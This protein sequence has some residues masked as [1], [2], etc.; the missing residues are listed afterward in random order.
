MNGF[1]VTT[2]VYKILVVRRGRVRI[3][4]FDSDE[5]A[6]ASHACTSIGPM[7][8]KKYRTA[9]L[10]VANQTRVRYTPNIVSNLLDNC[11][12]ERVDVL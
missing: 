6:K 3:A 1:F 12:A 5:V 2:I 9:L 11:G 7:S 10:V 4:L 8:I